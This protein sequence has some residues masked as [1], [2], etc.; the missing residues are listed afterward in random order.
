MQIIATDILEAALDNV[1]SVWTRL[2]YEYLIFLDVWLGLRCY[3]SLANKKKC[4]RKSQT[5]KS[6]DDWEEKNGKL[7]ITR[8]YGI[9]ASDFL[10]SFYEAR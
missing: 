1:Q 4:I 10:R 7:Q 6:R 2:P 8:I 5:Q 3:S 9:P